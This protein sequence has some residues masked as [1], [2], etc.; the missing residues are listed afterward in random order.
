VSPA[1]RDRWAKVPRSAVEQIGCAQ[2]FRLL[3][4]ADLVQGEDGWPPRGVRKAAEVLGWKPDTVK[5]HLDHLCDAGW[6]RAKRETEHGAFVMEVIHNPSRG[7]VNP[8][9]VPIG[10]R[11]K[12]LPTRP[13]PPARDQ[14]RRN[15]H[16]DTRNGTGTPDPQNGAGPRSTPDPQNGSD[17]TRNGGHPPDPQ[18]GAGPRSKR[19]E[20][21]S[22]GTRARSYSRDEAVAELL[23][24]LAGLDALRVLEPDE[25]TDLVRHQVDTAWPDG[26]VTVDDDLIRKTMLHCTGSLRGRAGT[27][28][29][30]GEVVNR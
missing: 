7:R 3:A 24:R 20:R 21:S 30:G 25:A 2:C 4:Y 10:E 27:R 26:S 6:M 13:P 1:P 18:N 22:R 15:A 12:R 28:R 9:A 17:L 5:R 19:S 16:P 11:A 29:A 23:R 8:A 14:A